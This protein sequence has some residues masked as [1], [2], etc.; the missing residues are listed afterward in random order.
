MNILQRTTLFL[1]LS[2]LLLV[3]CSKGENNKQEENEVITSTLGVDSLL[4][5]PDAFVDQEV[6]LEGVCAHICKHG[7]GKIFL[8]G[9]DDTK[10]IRV[11]AGDAIGS[12]T[13][14]RAGKF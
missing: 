3:G 12:F 8:M 1:F 9:S 10:T 11:E 7:G 5:N 13:T 14:T 4:S 6:V 2:T